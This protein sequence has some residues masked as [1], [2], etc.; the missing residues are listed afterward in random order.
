MKTL[1]G[2][3]TALLAVT[4]LAASPAG[5]APVTLNLDYTGFAE[6]YQTGIITDDGTSQHVAAGLFEFKV[7]NTQ[8]DSPITWSDTLQAFCIQTD[9]LLNKNPVN[10]TL[11][12]ATDHF[13]DS[14]QVDLIGQLYTGYR[15]QVTDATT[16]AG[17][18]LALWELVNESQS[19]KGLT[20]GDFTSNQFT[21]ARAK[22]D[23]WLSSLGSLVNEFE[24]YVLTSANSQDLL[25]FKPTPP[26]RVPEPATIALLALG[27]LAMGL[28]MRQ[29]R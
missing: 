8:G 24:L 5:A 20:A 7:S 13:G 14:H 3:L 23:E 27:L 6:G 12:S 28:R 22:A 15:N 18:Q 11:A 29:R 26:V 16:S 19:S 10:Y 1:Q 21:G 17:F 25:V 4:A 9:T 2:M